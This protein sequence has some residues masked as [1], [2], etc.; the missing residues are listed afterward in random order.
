[1]HTRS[2]AS[3]S[4]GQARLGQILALSA[5]AGVLGWTMSSTKTLYADESHIDDVHPESGA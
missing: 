3:S 5:V 4:T 2:V 1:M